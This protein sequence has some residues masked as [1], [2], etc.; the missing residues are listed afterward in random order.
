MCS[1][2][3]WQLEDFL[4]SCY[5]DGDPPAHV[6][7]DVGTSVGA[8]LKPLPVRNTHAL[9][10]PEHVPAQKHQD[11]APATPQNSPESMWK[12]FD[13]M[14]T[15]AR[16]LDC[17]QS[18]S[19]GNEQAL[20]QK[21]QSSTTLPLQTKGSFESACHSKSA[22]KEELPSS[23]L[24]EPEDA[25]KQPTSLEEF[26]Q[27]A[28]D[29][30]SGKKTGSG[31]KPMKRPAA[32]LKRPAAS[33]P[34]QRPSPT[35]VEKPTKVGK[36]K[37]GNLKYGCI[38]CRFEIAWARSMDQKAAAAESKGEIEERTLKEVHLLGVP[39]KQSGTNL[40]SSMEKCMGLPCRSSI[41]CWF[42]I[43]T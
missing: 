8:L 11:R 7:P 30:L 9:L 12:M 18:Q 6:P 22:S 28:F 37:N 33:K 1:F 17:F 14:L 40:E 39:A 26:E 29:L 10:Q 5:E 3:V 41:C 43:R 36:H 38:R 24:A 13:L 32:C 23:P 4:K 42:C 19:Q 21:Q 15:R 27:K 31:Q 20:Q 16:S 2:V 25:D 35:S 34:F